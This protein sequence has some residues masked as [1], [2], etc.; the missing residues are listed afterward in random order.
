M[1]EECLV[2]HLRAARKTVIFPTNRVEFVGA[3]DQVV[4]MENGAIAYQVDRGGG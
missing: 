3:C 2:K 4:V 1:F